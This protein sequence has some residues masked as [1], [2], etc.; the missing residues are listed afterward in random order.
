MK[1]I[2]VL[3]CGR[4]MCEQQH[5]GHAVLRPFVQKRDIVPHLGV[6][7]CQLRAG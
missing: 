3:F 4:D 2:K 7:P 5:A 6:L 1:G